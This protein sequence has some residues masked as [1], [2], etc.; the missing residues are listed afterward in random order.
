MPVPGEELA[1]GVTKGLAQFNPV[2]KVMDMAQGSGDWLMQLL[3]LLQQLFSGQQQPQI[4]PEMP[5]P[6]Q[7]QQKPL[8]AKGLRG[9]LLEY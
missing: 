2:T 4:P 9:K 3:P 1:Q 6:Q 7:G 5:L 8:P